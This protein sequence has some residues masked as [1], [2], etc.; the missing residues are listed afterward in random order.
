[1][2]NTVINAHHTVQGNIKWVCRGRWEGWVAG[3]WERDK[4]FS[5]LCIH[6]INQF[7]HRIPV[8][9]VLFKNMMINDKTCD[10][11]NNNSN[12]N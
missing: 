5:I 2:H 6:N 3:Y 1:M 12:A 10:T 8:A 4:E 7:E 11:Y 9:P